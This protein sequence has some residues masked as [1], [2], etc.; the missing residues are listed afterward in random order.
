MT[1]P[2]TIFVARAAAALPV[3]LFAFAGCFSPDLGDGVIFCGVGDSCP[4]GYECRDDHCFRRGG[5]SG[6]DLGS[7][8]LSVDDVV[9]LAGAT[10]DLA[11][12]DFARPVGDLAHLPGADLA[13]S[14]PDLATSPPDLATTT[15]NRLCSSGCSPCCH[16]SCNGTNCACASSS[17]AC[18]FTC[19]NNTSCA[20]ACSDGARCGGAVG[21]MA[22]ATINCNDATCEYQ[23]RNNSRCQLNCGGNSS[24]SL[25]CFNSAQCTLTG[26]TGGPAQTCADGTIVCHHACP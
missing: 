23:C 20:I 19:S 22:N 8:D 12:A 18:D 11:N 5:A 25:R 7:D 14:P 6:D 15:C 21:N 17:C 2:G 4:P 16:Q 26:C 3:A 1:P 10:G 9:D 24:C 13:T